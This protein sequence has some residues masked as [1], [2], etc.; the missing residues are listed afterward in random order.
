MPMVS[1]ELLS[2]PS[3]N[4]K[5]GDAHSYISI[6]MTFFIENVSLTKSVKKVHRQGIRLSDVFS[7]IIGVY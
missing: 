6:L 5:A 2:L 3:K 1:F 4:R 7:F